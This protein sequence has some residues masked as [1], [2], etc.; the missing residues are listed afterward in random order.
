MSV[1]INPSSGGGG[2]GMAIGGPVVGGTPG[3]VLF[4]DG[5]G[6]LGQDNANFFW[7]NTA[8]ALKL[9]KTLLVASGAIVA[10]AP[11]LTL[12]QTW[13]NAAVFFDAALLVNITNTASNTGAVYSKDGNKFNSLILDIQVAGVTYFG[14]DCINS[15]YFISPNTSATNLVFSNTS[16]GIGASSNTWTFGL[17]GIGVPSST[18]DFFIYSANANAGS[19]R[20]SFHI[21]AAGSNLMPNSVLLAWTGDVAFVNPSNVDVGFARNAA[22]LVEVNNGAKGTF[23]DLIL[24]DIFTN[25][26]TFFLRTKTSLTNSAAAATAT[27]TNAPVA[28]NP[29]KWIGIDDNGVTRQIPAW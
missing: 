7:D 18:G 22:G 2:G 27:L 1:I 20:E 26:A 4:V 10:S 21:T 11:A 3:S 25:D 24:R 19:G 5:S 15:A 17:Y 16:T 14:V 9:A 28:G 8:K 23:R 12:T 13:N 29:T 6:N